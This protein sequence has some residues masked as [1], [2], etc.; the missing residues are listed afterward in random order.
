MALVSTNY[1]VCSCFVQTFPAWTIKI[2]RPPYSCFKPTQHRPPLNRWK[3]PAELIG[4]CSS[5]RFIYL[6]PPV[7]VHAM[8]ADIACGRTVIDVLYP[9]IGTPVIAL[10]WTN[11]NRVPEIS[12][13]GMKTELRPLRFAH[14]ARIGL[15]AAANVRSSRT[16]SKSQGC[17]SVCRLVLQPERRQE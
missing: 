2:V 6:V 16:C 1:L 4:R 12:H 14:E 3:V 9:I 13:N 8:Q 7:H 10:I 17:N 15:P 11:E 5:P